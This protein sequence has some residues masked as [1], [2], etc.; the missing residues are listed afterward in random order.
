MPKPSK[1]PNSPV[2]R[3]SEMPRRLA[4]CLAGVP[5]ICDH[6]LCRREKRCLGPDVACFDKHLDRILADLE[7]GAASVAGAACVAGAASE[8]RTAGGQPPA[9]GAG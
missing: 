3:T 8:A 4:A 2:I 6:R 7:A 1:S 5:A 9:C